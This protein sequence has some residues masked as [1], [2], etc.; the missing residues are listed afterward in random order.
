M[1]QCAGVD[2]SRQNISTDNS[3]VDANFFACY[4]DPTVATPF[5]INFQTDPDNEDILANITVSL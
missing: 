2:Q 4:P 1:E 5:D 3:S